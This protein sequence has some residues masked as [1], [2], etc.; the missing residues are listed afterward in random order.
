MILQTLLVT[1]GSGISSTEIYVDS[2]SA[3]TYAA[4][5]PRARSYFMAAMM[6]VAIL[7]L[8]RITLQ[9]SL[10]ANPP[11]LTNAFHDLRRG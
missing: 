4:S 5:L 6:L 11:I 2:T 3:W 10:S 8:K 7:R 9:S 1:G